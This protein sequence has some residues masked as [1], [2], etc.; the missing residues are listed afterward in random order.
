MTW[1]YSGQ[2][3]QDLEDVYNIIGE[4]YTADHLEA[5]LT[6]TLEDVNICGWTAGAGRVVR[7][8][9]PIQFAEWLEVERDALA[10]HAIYEMERGPFPDGVAESLGFAWRDD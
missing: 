2:D 10:R 8:L 1:T 7:T 6:E 4:V 3:L 5:D 9:D